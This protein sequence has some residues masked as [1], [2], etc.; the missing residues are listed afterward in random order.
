VV[1]T[2]LVLVACATPPPNTAAIAVRAAQTYGPQCESDGPT[3]TQ[4]WGNC[5]ARAYDRA[6]AKHGDAC[7][8][9]QLSA[10]SYED[11]VMNA[12]VRDGAGPVAASAGPYCI[13]LNPGGD[14]NYS[15]CR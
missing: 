1:A 8:T 10:K 2:A 3:N 15:R 11:C 12:S 13:A 5:I 6:V 14:I 9:W 7:T 4:A